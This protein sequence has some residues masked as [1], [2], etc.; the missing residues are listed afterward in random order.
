MVNVEVA[1]LSSLIVVTLCLF[2]VLGAL[3]WV[4]SSQN[5]RELKYIQWGMSKNIQEFN[6]A[7]VTTAEVQGTVKPPEQS[8]YFSESELSDEDWYK[9]I[10]DMSSQSVVS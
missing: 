2:G 5:Q 10:K 1:L 9:K 4:L 7:Q 8:P 6:K 3:V